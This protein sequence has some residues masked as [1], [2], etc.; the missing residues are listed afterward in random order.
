MKISA[1]NI[2]KG[3][4]T[5]IVKGAT[6]Q[7]RYWG[8]GV[9]RFRSGRVENGGFREPERSVHFVREH[10]KRRRLPFAGRH[11]LNINMP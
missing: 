3:T 9:L 8:L 11:H 10:R 4:T 1:R 6:V 5:V 2:P 7:T